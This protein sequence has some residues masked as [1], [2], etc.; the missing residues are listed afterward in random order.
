MVQAYRVWDI[1]KQKNSSIKTAALF[2]QNTMYA[3]P[4][5]IVTP[6]PLHMD[7]GL[8][9]WCYS[10]PAGYYDEELMQNLGE[11]KLASY[12]GPFASSQSSEWIVRAAE[13]TLE[14]QR[15][16]MMFT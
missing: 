2:Y 1:V 9:M 5:V 15:P 16:D 7:V 6:R 14:M 3:N 11:F 4:D 10:K 12:W 13:Y 8:I